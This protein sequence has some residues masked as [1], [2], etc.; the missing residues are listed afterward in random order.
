MSRF[1]LRQAAGGSSLRSGD[2]LR[3]DLEA[4]AAEL[5]PRPIVVTADGPITGPMVGYSFIRVMVNPPARSQW[6]RPVIVGAQELPA[7]RPYVNVVRTSVEVVVAATGSGRQLSRLNGCRSR[8]RSFS[9]PGSPPSPWVLLHDRRQSL[10]LSGRNSS[11]R[12]FS[13]LG[14]PSS[15]PWLRR[16][17]RFERR[18]SRPMVPSRHR[19]SGRSVTAPIRAFKLNRDH[20]QFGRQWLRHRSRRRRFG[21]L[22]FGRLLRKACRFG[23]PLSM[24]GR[25]R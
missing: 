5:S 16:P 10:R 21:K 19:S 13:K 7:Q 8:R 20:R 1:T 6:P 24:P 12:L 9:K 14:S 2:T 15:H 3:G 23:Q 4:E 22:L 11:R 25:C 18:L 17:C